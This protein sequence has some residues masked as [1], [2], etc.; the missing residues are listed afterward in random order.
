MKI[1]E[2]GGHLDQMMRQTRAHHV[3]LSVM[4]DLKANALMTIAAVLLTFSAAF[5]VREQFR[6][7]VI[8]LMC[9]CLVTI[10]LAT[11]AVMPGTPL[12]IKRRKSADQPTNSGFN[13]L[14]FGSFAGMDYAQFAAAME[15]TMNDPSKTYEAMVREVY[16]LGV[17][18]ARKKYRYLRLAYIVF[19]T[20]LFAAG[21]T[22][23]LT[24]VL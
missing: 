8:V 9:S 2:A 7:A 20:G 24:N 21:T 6:A 18:L 17:Y 13:L 15:E 3:Q 5:V 4:G 19:T 23:L 12:Q 1:H 22:L 16:T 10:L 14:F 11:F